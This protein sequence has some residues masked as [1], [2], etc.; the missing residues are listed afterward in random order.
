M[1]E[2]R[3]P[4]AACGKRSDR[5]L[6]LHVFDR[7]HPDAEMRKQRLRQNVTEFVIDRGSTGRDTVASSIATKC[8]KKCTMGRT[9]VATMQSAYYVQAILVWLE[10]TNGL[11]KL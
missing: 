3:L 9:G 6:A 8:A 7:V 2:D 1:H 4:R 5:W 11:R 10:R